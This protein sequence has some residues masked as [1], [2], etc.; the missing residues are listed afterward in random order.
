MMSEITAEYCDQRVREERA[1]AARASC[2]EAAKVHQQLAREFEK[3][4][5][6]LRSGA[7]ATRPSLFSWRS[8]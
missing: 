5:I 2:S 4:A 3:K 1:A 6:A 7:E 8:N